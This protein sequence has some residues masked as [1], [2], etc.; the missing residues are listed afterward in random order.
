MNISQKREWMRIN[1]LPALKVWLPD[2][3]SQRCIEIIESGTDAQIKDAWER[4]F[5][6]KVQS[7][8]DSLRMPTESLPG[9]V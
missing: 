2:I 1:T 7:L 4:F 5:A 3:G 9:Y 6:G 8:Q